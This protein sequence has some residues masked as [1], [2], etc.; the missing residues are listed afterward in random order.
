MRWQRILLTLLLIALSM[1]AMAQ[2]W[3]R[4]SIAYQPSRD[5]YLIYQRDSLGAWQLRNVLKGDEYLRERLDTLNWS[6][7]YSLNKHKSLQPKERP[8][9]KLQANGYLRL[10]LNNTTI[11]DD[12]P[13]IPVGLRRRSFVD[14]KQL[15]NIHLQGSYGERIKLD[16][17]YNTETALASQRRRLRLQFEGEEHDFIQR[18]QA[19]N[20]RMESRNPLIDTGQE[21]FGIRGDFLLGPFSLQVVASRQHSEERRIVV[22]GGRQLRQVERKSS[23]YD[24]AQHFF[25]SE[26]FAQQYDHALRAIPLIESELYIDRIEV[27]VSTSRE[28]SLLPNIE[29]IV[30]YTSASLVDNTPPSE[31]S[32]GTSPTLHIPSAQRL[33]ES[34]Y[35]LNP[36]LGFISLNTPLSEGLVLAVA[37]SYT[38]QGK[39]YQVGDFQSSNGERKTALISGQDLSPNSPLWDLMMKNGYS[40][41][42]GQRQLTSEDLQVALLL[43]D[44]SAGIEK[45]I[46]ERG[47]QAG[48]SWLDLFGWDRTNRSGSKNEPDGQFDLIEGVTYSSK[49][50][51]LFLPFRRPFESVPQEANNGASFYPVYTSLYDLSRREAQQSAELD[52]YVIR[53]QVS[54]SSTQIVSLDSRELTPGSVRVESGGRTLTEGN[55]YTIN[56]ATGYLTLTSETNERVEI[57]IQEHERSRRKEKSLV[58]TE[59]NWSPL[60]GLNIGT[61]WLTYWEDSHRDR[62]RWGEEALKSMMWG[63]HASYKSS[64]MAPTRWLNEWWGMDLKEPSAL[65]IQTSYAQLH[66]SYNLPDE[67]DHIIIEDFEQ[68]NQWIDLTFPLKWQLGSLPSPELRAQMAWFTIDPLLVADGAKYQPDH[69]RADKE[70]RKHPLVRQVMT[71]ELFPKRDQNPILPNNLMLLNLSYYPEERGPY[72]LDA[73]LITPEGKT[74]NP[75]SLWGSIMTTLPIRDLE[76]SRYSYIEVWMLDPY[77]VGLDSEGTLL[78]DLGKIKEEII[79]DGGLSYEGAQEKSQTEWGKRASQPPQL[80]GFDAT[81][82][83]PME[84]QDVGLNG[85]S[86]KEEKGHPT[87]ANY[88]EQLTNITNMDPWKDQ[89]FGN[90]EQDP[91]GDDYQFFLGDKW[92]QIKAPILE[93]YKYI[94][95][96]EGNALDNVI[97]GVRSAATW[98]PDTEDLNRD[99]IQSL[100]ESFFRYEV[101]ISKAGL[102]NVNPNIVSEKI[103]QNGERWVKLRIP[104]KEPTTILGN[105]P[106]LQDVRTVRLSLT[107]FHKRIHLRLAQLRII[108]TAWSSYDAAIDPSDRRTA[109]LHVGSLSTEEDSDRQP[110]PYVSPPGIHREI[111]H[112][113]ISL[114]RDD[115]QALA[116]EFSEI[117]PEQ[118]VAVFQEQSLDLRHYKQLQLFTHLHSPLLITKGEVELFIRIG[119]DYTENYYEYALQLTPTPISDYQGMGEHELQQLIWLP[120]NQLNITLEALTHLKQERAQTGADPSVP[121][122]RAILSSNQ[123][124]KMSIKGHP[125]LGKVSAMLIGVRNRSDHTI[126]GEVWINELAL[127]GARDLGGKAFQGS[128]RANLAE[129]A[130]LELDGRYQSAGFGGVTQDLRK[131]EL[132]DLKAFN[133]RS[134]LELGLLLPSSWQVNAPIIYAYNIQR[135]SPLY[136]PYNNDLRYLPSDNHRA[137]R[138]EMLQSF[139]IKDLYADPKRDQKRF[140]HINNFHFTYHLLNRKS[141]SPE[142]EDDINRHARSDLTYTFEPRQQNYYRLSSRWNRL[143]HYQRYTG[144]NE[145][146]TLNTLLSRWDWERALNIR[147]QILPGLQAVIQSNTMALIDEPFEQNH[148]YDKSAEFKLFTQKIGRDILSLGK[149]MHYNNMIELGYRLPLFHKRGWQG[150]QGTATWRSNYRW[151]RGRHITGREI[152]NRAEN[153]TYLDVLLRYDFSNLYPKGKAQFVKSMGIHY[154]QTTGSAIP[155]LLP[156]AGKALGFSIYQKELAPSILYFLGLDHHNKELRR[157]YD[158]GW[159]T[160]DKSQIRPLTYFSRDEIDATLHMTPIKG[161]EIDLHWL[162]SNHRHHE[163]RGDVSSLELLTNGSQRFSI[164]AHKGSKQLDVNNLQESFFQKYAIGGR[165]KDG[166]PSLL[167]TLPNM[168][169]AYHFTH[170]H[171]WLTEQFTHLQI[172]HRYASYIDIPNYHLSDDESMPYIPSMTITEDFNPLIGLSIGTKSG[173]N[174]EERYIQRKSYTLL[175]TSQQLLEQSDHEISSAINVAFKFKPLFQSTLKWLHSFEQQLSLQLH[176]RFTKSLLYTELLTTGS[177][178][179][180]QGVLNHTLQISAEYGLSEVISLRA[181]YELQNRRPL[182]SNYNHPY[183]RTSYGIILNLQLH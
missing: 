111:R 10:N 97:Q 119:Q 118:A 179:A 73:S 3:S 35:T 112:Q 5:L 40:L 12:N 158:R 121:F 136:D 82:N 26:F 21:L 43:R 103:L 95:G 89:P 19:G 96:T 72:N 24:V 128:M 69:L 79:P 58:G 86:S 132:M 48:R 166:L 18:I 54:G 92:D 56:Y 102:S 77:S 146:T 155:G 78:L 183:R 20:V 122:I 38:Y 61:S 143:Y 126:R 161:L 65:E 176:H 27:W 42:S 67:N 2:Q 55:D 62:I 98:Q 93:R 53:S 168:E 47:E 66:S 1:T 123:G 22:Q 64:G 131:S 13:A 17:S 109:A 108:S 46:V 135:S 88:L 127:T 85:L 157:V 87:Y 152:G 32:F 9:L 172:R 174:I 167:S 180:T 11:T 23:D 129:L 51:T 74:N 94:N 30:A 76:S 144:S 148:L 163:L 90:P 177:R 31:Q 25:L 4:D 6:R 145:Q 104:L 8:P 37:Y 137:G 175:S 156:E 150:L 91:A 71:Q 14:F 84:V 50:S 41:Q 44:P 133:I 101:S 63:I 83:I 124:E 125:T 107:N 181:F 159:I 153:A 45:A 59:L 116:L 141:Y 106:S 99:M 68:G 29:P 171:P 151:D 178:S 140:Y 134:K 36:T 113:A 120:N 15:A 154:R 165:F 110:I 60:A 100:E 117:E 130:S 170:L 173:I 70:Q 33:P 75:A 80:Y 105:N 39:K 160:T 16:L 169:I 28:G 52:G 139:E 162:T 34:A 147:Q 114:A 81:G 49:S 115:E 142:L 149:T 138:M 164:I 7:F 57:I 182:V